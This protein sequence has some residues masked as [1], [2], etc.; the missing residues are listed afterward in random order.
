ME[1]GLSP[2]NGLCGVQQRSAGSTGR[3]VFWKARPDRV[4]SIQVMEQGR[5]S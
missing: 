4:W 3:L 5:V 2:I 1:N